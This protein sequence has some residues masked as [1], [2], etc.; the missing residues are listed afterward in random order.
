LSLSKIE[1]LR[2]AVANLLLR[3]LL[4]LLGIV[5]V[6][7]EAFGKK[8]NQAIVEDPYDS[9]SGG[10]SL[11]RA[12][13]ENVVL[14]NPALM[15]YGGKFHRWVGT[16][17]TLLTNRESIDFVQSLA[18]QGSS[19]D[20]ASSSGPAEFIERVF[21]TP[22]HAGIQNITSYTTN[23]FGLGVFAR[24]EMDIQAREFGEFGMPEL[25]FGVDAYLGAAAGFGLRIVRFLSVGV[26]AKYLLV[27]EPDIAVSLLDATRI[28]E[29]SDPAALQDAASYGMG[30]GYDLGALLFLQGRIVDY[31]LALKVDDVGG[32]EF[33][34]T[35][36]PFKQ[37][38]HAGT[39]LTFH[40]SADALHLALD[41]RD[42][43]GA[44]EEPI[45]KRIY[46][47]ARLSIRQYVGIAAGLYQGYPSYGVRLDLLLFKLG[48]TAYT[49]EL[50]QYP[51]ENPRNLYQIY[52]MTGF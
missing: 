43:Q 33:S 18:G 23:N 19:S 3:F 11:T 6:P 44:Y 32:T 4:V 48:A 24:T 22:I 50:G 51:G 34:G 47:G 15:P 42:I 21:D 14:S 7:N 38:I 46:T 31:R 2:I 26:T 28:Q 1:K 36:D 37:T 35:Q 40:N 8:T 45:F 39:S 49:R 20:E 25:R 12:T 13:R 16:Q 30:M 27:A 52:F 10:A 9:A 41:Y 29:L 17:F 5:Q